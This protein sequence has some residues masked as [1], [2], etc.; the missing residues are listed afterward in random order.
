[1]TD[2]RYFGRR[3][4]PLTDLPEYD[5]GSGETSFLSDLKL[6][7]SAFAAGFLFVAVYIA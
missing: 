2:R 3:A 4:H 6:F 7:T 1:M 5:A